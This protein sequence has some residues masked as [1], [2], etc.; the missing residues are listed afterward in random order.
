[1][2]KI[3]TLEDDLKKRLENPAFRKAW[4][5][6]EVEYNLMVQLIEKRLKNNLSQRALAK[7]VGT[8]QSVIA[9]IEGMDANPSIGLLKRIAKALDTK[10]SISL[11]NG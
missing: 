1:M 3:Y 8:S 11:I 9:R 2:R 4:E 7:K 5:E 6:S 10:L